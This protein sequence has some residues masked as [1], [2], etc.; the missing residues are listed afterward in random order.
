MKESFWGIFVVFLG[1]LGIT[2]I[3]LFQNITNTD[4][5]NSQ[6]LEEVTEAAMRDAIDY[7][8]Y[9]DDGRIK[10]NREKFV[11]NFIRRYAESASK[12]RD[13]KIIF[14]SINESPPKVS[15]AV[16]SGVVGAAGDAEVSFDLTNKID[17]ILETPY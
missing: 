2:F 15:L 3:V 17:A 6:L 9:R 13:Y 16:K 8:S 14:Y 10:I 12:S 1:V 11:E 5:H 4:Q 7:A